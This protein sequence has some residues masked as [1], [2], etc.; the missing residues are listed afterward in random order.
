MSE[1]ARLTGVVW[2]PGL[3]FQDIAAHT[4]WWPPVALIIVVSL[5]FTYS[6]T[7]RVGWERF[8]RQQMEAN[9]RAQNM[10]A[11]QRE[12]SIATGARVA[13]I[14]GYGASVVG[15]PVMALVTAGVFLLLLRNALG[16]ELSFR[17]VFAIVCYAWLPLLFSSMMAVAVLLL[18]NPDDFDLEHPT[19]TNIGAFLEPSTSKWLLSLA[20]SLDVFTLWALAIMATGF[21]VA[22]R[23]LSWSSSFSCVLGTWF[24]WVLVK[25][26]WAAIRG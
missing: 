19:L 25:M 5:V 4:R 2:S 24:V 18:K 26:G 7:E 10:P 16:A 14:V 3:A 9:P 12:Q 13:G 1:L 15:F 8:M 20:T 23:K 21:S 6:F 22:A 17:Q 11:D